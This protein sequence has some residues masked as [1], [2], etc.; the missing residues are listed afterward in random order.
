MCDYAR[1]KNF[2]IIII[3]IIIYLQSYNADVIQHC[4]SLNLLSEVT[5]I[6]EILVH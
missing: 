2:H 6:L 4:L 3:I 5:I 1:V